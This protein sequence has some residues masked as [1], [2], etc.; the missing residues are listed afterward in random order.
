[1]L[2]KVGNYY[3]HIEKFLS[4]IFFTISSV[5]QEHEENE[6]DKDCIYIRDVRTYAE[7]LLIQIILRWNDTF[8]AAFE[9]EC[10]YEEY[11]II[12]EKYQRESNI[13]EQNDEAAKLANGI[14]E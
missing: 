11:E 6:K 2:R 14:A 10:I 8:T 7:D 13:K 12:L 9:K 1:V 3:S 4:S 5:K